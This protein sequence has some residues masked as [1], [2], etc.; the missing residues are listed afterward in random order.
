ML[1]Y[2]PPADPFARAQRGSRSRRQRGILS[3]GRL[4]LKILQ[5]LSREGKLGQRLNFPLSYPGFRLQAVLDIL[6]TQSLYER[7]PLE[8]SIGEYLESFR[9]GTLGRCMP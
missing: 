8:F 3:L 4:D 6:Y 7:L 9:Q 1:K 5:G 2:Y